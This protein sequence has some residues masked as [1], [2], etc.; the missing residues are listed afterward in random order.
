M[1]N[2]AQSGPLTRTTAMADV[3]TGVARATIVSV[4]RNMSPTES[5]GSPK[6]KNKHVVLKRRV[7]LLGGG[8]GGYFGPNL[9]RDGW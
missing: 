6:S 3:P 5:G 4:E 7:F 8:I 1:A 9:W 2:A